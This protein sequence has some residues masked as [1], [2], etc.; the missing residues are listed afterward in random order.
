M[1][2]CEFAFLNA[3]L[4]YGVTGALIVKPSDLADV[5]RWGIYLQFDYLVL[6]KDFQKY[7]LVFKT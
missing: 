7:P 6:D 5:I 3:V 1:S 4:F 2:D